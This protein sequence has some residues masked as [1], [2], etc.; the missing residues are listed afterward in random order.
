ML[1]VSIRLTLMTSMGPFQPYIL[2]IP[3]RNSSPVLIWMNF[4]H[5][6]VYELPTILCGLHPA[7]SWQLESYKDNMWSGIKCGIAAR[8]VYVFSRGK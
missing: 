3:L 6:P 8:V 4:F 5:S 1:V 7:F 2:C